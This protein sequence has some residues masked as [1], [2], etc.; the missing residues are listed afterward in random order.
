MASA[1]CLSLSAFLTHHSPLLRRS[2]TEFLS[3]RAILWLTRPL[4]LRDCE[5]LFS[6]RVTG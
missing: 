1:F 5:G 4:V 6:N 2:V 3:E